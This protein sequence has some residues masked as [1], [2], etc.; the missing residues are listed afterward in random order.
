MCIIIN[1]STKEKTDGLF[2]WLSNFR[3]LLKMWPFCKQNLSEHNGMKRFM[4]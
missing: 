3:K 2:M 1:H 4:F